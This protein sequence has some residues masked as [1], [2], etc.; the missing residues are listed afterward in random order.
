MPSQWRGSPR[1]PPGWISLCPS[2]AEDAAGLLNAAFESGRPTLFF[3]PKNLLNNRELASRFAPKSLL[4]P[5]GKARIEREGRDI[6]LVAWGNTTVHCR[7]AAEALAGAGAEAEVL[8]LRTLRP[9][10]KAAVLASVRKTGR[11]II[12]HE[13]THTAGMGAEV[14]AAVAEEIQTPVRVKRVTRA[15]TFVPCNFGNQLE[16]LPSYK[17]VLEAAVELLDGEIRWQRESEAGGESY[18]LEAVG[19]SPSDEVVTVIEWL[20]K[21]GEQV[22]E[23]QEL[24]ELEA[25]KAMVTLSS[26][27]AGIVV[28]LDTA[29]GESA[30]VGAGIATLQLEQGS[31]RVKPVTR[32]EPGTPVITGLKTGSPAAA[33]AVH[34]DRAGI[35]VIAGVRGVMGSE[36]I[37]N[38]AISRLCPTWSPEDILKRTGIRERRWIGKGETSLTLSVAAAEALFTDT[39]TGIEEIDLLL[40]STTTP[41]LNTPSMATLIQHALNE[42]YGADCNAPAYDINAACSGYVYGLQIAH[43]YLAQKPDHRILLITTDVPFRPNRYGR[44]LDRSGIRR[45]CDGDPDCRCCRDR[46]RT[47]RDST[48]GSLRPGRGRLAAPNPRRPGTSDLH[49]GSRGLSEGGL[50]DGGHSAQGLR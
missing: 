4:L 49:G 17:A 20:V 29:E 42:K 19:S 30:D 31:L 16:V 39:R 32:E 3:Y 36:V 24:A 25:D 40:C 41:I 33:G 38:E 21:P 50:R 14:V 18:I 45:R 43:D 26:P 47:P 2:R 15:D 10:D 9:W 34:R 44:S 8:D 13:D 23:G 5:P 28:S 12:V 46:G 1:R 7:R 6:T 37:S 35:A 22:V 27:V 48:A 11:L